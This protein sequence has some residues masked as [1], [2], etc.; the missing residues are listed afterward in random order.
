MG[1]YANLTPDT[2]DSEQA[3]LYKIAV[4][5]RTLGTAL[6]GSSSSTQEAIARSA[7]TQSGSIPAGFTRITIVSDSTYTG[8]VQGAVFP[9]SYAETFVAQT[10]KTLGGISYTVG[11]GTLYI[12]TTT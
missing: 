11:A 2:Q 8:T 1:D 4:G 5:T 6:A 7:V 3:L 10:G 9:Q 12:T